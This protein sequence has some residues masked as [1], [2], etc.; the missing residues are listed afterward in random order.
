MSGLWG[1]ELSVVKYVMG[2]VWASLQVE[3]ITCVMTL[4]HVPFSQALLTLQ[5]DRSTGPVFF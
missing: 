2:A 1:Y 3:K 4:S 5:Q